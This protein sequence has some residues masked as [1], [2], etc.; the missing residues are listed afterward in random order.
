MRTQGQ[1]SRKQTGPGRLQQASNSQD[2]PSWEDCPGNP[3]AQGVNPPSSRKIP[4]P[5]PWP[6]G[7]SG[8]TA[9]ETSLHTAPRGLGPVCAHGAPGYRRSKAPRTVEGPV[10]DTRICTRRAK[11]NTARLGPPRAATE[12]RKL[13]QIQIKKETP[14]IGV[15]LGCQGLSIW[16]RKPARFGEP[17]T[18]ALHL[19]PHPCTARRGTPKGKAA[20]R[21]RVGPALPCA[22]TPAGSDGQGPS[23]PAPACA[24]ALVPHPGVLAPSPP[25]PIPL[26][27]TRELRGASARIR[28]TAPPSR[29]RSLSAHMASAPRPRSAHTAPPL[30]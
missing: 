3:C 21:P 26:R 16:G 22:P 5:S 23:S 28:P 24:R 4:H 12:I 1:S 8:S 20:V 7:R 9:T 17:H 18:T 10:S 6:P 25:L 15:P 29:T 2:T 27:G 14:P 13:N 30:C 11:P 19:G